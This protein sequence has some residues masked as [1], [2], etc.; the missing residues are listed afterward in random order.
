VA[1]WMMRDARGHVV[2]VNERTR[3]RLELTVT[4]V[5]TVPGFDATI[6]P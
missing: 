5:D 6:W 2:Y 3:R 1:E 4:R